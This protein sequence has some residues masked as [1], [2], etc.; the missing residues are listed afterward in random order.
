[1]AIVFWKKQRSA[2]GGIPAKRTT[3]TSEIFCETEQMRDRLCGLVVRI[4]GY[5]YGGPGSIPG[6]TRKKK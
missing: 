4:L 5:R 2:D 1:M 6:T 3:I